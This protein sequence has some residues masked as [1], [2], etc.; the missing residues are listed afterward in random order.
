MSFASLAVY[1]MANRMRAGNFMIATAIQGLQ[2][3]DRH[4]S[5]V[6]V[7]SSG[8]RRSCGRRTGSAGVLHPPSRL[9][10]RGGRVV[11]QVS[12][13]PQRLS[14]LMRNRD[15]RVTPDAWQLRL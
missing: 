1:L 3:K 8:V 2:Y 12:G 11:R 10:P 6:R 4:C 15:C 7:C 14:R 9:A 13:V 5:E